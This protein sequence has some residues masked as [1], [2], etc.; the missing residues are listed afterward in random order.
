MDGIPMPGEFSLFHFN[1][2]KTGGS[3]KSTEDQ[4]KT[5]VWWVVGKNKLWGMIEVLAIKYP[6]AAG[7][8]RNVGGEKDPAHLAVDRS[9]LGLIAGLKALPKTISDNVKTHLKPYT[10]AWELEGEH[11]NV[12]RYGAQAFAGPTGGAADT[13]TFGQ[14][15]AT[16]LRTAVGADIKPDEDK[17]IYA[18]MA[19]EGRLSMALSLIENEY[20]IRIKLLQGQFPLINLFDVYLQAG[21]EGR[22]SASIH[23]MASR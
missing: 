13:R 3:G 12:Y 18:D 9:A 20:A 22:A 11:S 7:V 6:F 17:A 8:G 15:A 14:L 16:L 19:P 1:E 5:L 2:N 10:D 4:I 23:S 21:V